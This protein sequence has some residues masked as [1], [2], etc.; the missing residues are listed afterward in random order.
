MGEQAGPEYRPRRSVLYLPATNERAREKA[1]TLPVDAVVLDLEDAVAPAAKDAARAAACTAVRGGGYG[2]RELAV[3]VNAPGTGWHDDD[4]RAVAE[5][6]PD[7]VVV[8]KLSSAEEVR[9]VAEAL[10]AAGA[11]ERTALWAMLETPR[12]VLHAEEI[13]GA[14]P[15]LTVLVLGTNDL[16]NALRAARV[17]GRQP[18]LAAL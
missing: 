12:A 8:P 3:R 1:R 5:A 7:A 18:L 9:R 6:A 17:P 4:L 15:R 2:R 16:A 13:A 11:P 14:S 10:A